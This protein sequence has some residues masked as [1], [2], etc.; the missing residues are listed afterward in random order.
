MKTR[1]WLVAAVLAATVP[2]IAMAQ[3]PAA[4][5]APRANPGAGA[6]APVDGKI[7]VINTGAFA[8]KILEL[9]AKADTV[10]KQ[11]EPRFK[12]LQTM[13]QQIDTLEA[14]IRKQQNVVAQD[15]LQKMQDQ[16]V[17]LTT[18]YK[19]QGEDLQAE[20]NKAAQTS[21]QPVQQKLQDFV[22]DYSAKR[23]IVLILDLPGSYQAGIIGY[24]NQAIDITDDFIAEYNKA[25]PVPGAAPAAARPAS[26]GR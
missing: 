21:L 24:F 3:G 9:K 14:D 23:N 6:A 19:R 12:T 7:A 20:Y 13:K 25:N 26:G 2:T 15:V 11:Y 5:T 22:R 16:Y 8:D 17:Q 1:L 18:Q 10:N 4:P